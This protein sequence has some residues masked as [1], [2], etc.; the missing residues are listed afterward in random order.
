MRLLSLNIPTEGINPTTRLVMA[1]DIINIIGQNLDN[2]YQVPLGR[3]YDDGLWCYTC[4]VKLNGART[5][6]KCGGGRS[7]GNISTGYTFSYFL[8]LGVIRELIAHFAKWEIFEWTTTD[9]KYSAIST[10]TGTDIALMLDDC[11][12][13]AASKSLRGLQ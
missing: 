12:E 9:Q 6:P 13:I 2:P 4:R 5:C 8:D 3:L 10:M 1:Q 7:K 11:M